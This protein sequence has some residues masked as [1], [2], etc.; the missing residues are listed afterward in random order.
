VARNTTNVLQ[1]VN[2]NEFLDR[3]A[4]SPLPAPFHRPAH[5]L[6]YAEWHMTGLYQIKENGVL[7][8]LS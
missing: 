8:S 7:V 2:L 3:G 5:F 6:S 4:S 1:N